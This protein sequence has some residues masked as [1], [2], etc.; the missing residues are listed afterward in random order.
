MIQNKTGPA[1]ALYYDR[2]SGR[3]TEIYEDK[4]L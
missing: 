3:M 4:T 1:C 2:I